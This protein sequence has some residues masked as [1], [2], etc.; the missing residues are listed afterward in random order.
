MMRFP[1]T[2]VALVAS[3]FLGALPP[4]DLQAVCFV[5]A[6]VQRRPSLPLLLQPVLSQLEAALA[7]QSD[8]GATAAAT[9]KTGF[10]KTFL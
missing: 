3:R 2:L 4:V 9:R 10:K 7:L 8:G 5:G 6:T 1:P